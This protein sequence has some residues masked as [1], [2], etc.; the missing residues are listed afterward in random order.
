M[1]YRLLDWSKNQEP[2]V[3]SGA[4]VSFVGT[5]AA[6]LALWGFPMSD[7]ARNAL[8]ATI[9]VVV[10]V[11]MGLAAF[12]RQLVTPT[13]KAVTAIANALVEPPPPLTT[14]DAHLIRHAETI[15]STT[16]P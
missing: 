7:A 5:I 10:T 2:A 8:L 14:P 4:L 9:P 15:L 3:M 11:V 13:P 1:F 12:I 16:T 6:L